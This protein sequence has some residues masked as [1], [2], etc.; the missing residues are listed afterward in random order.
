MK[1]NMMNFEV[2]QQYTELLEK[3][4]AGEFENFEAINEAFDSSIL[5]KFSQQESGDRWRGTFAK[6]FY[7]HAG[8]QLDKITNEDFI[9]LNNPT[10]W[11]TQGYAKNDSAIGFFVDDNPELFKSWDKRLQDRM[12]EQGKKLKLTKVLRNAQGIGLILTIMRGKRGMWHGFQIDNQGSSFRYKKG[13]QERYGVLADQWKTDSKYRYEGVSSPDAKITRKNLEAVATK[14][15]VL[16][17]AALQSKYSSAEIKAA[18]SAAKTG[19]AAFVTAKQVKD[20]NQARYEELLQA[21][22]TP[23]ELWND[24]SGA[25]QKYLTWFTS[26]LGDITPKKAS[27]L[28]NTQVKFGGWSR[29]NLSRPITQM[30]DTISRMASD[31]DYAM[32]DQVHA[33][34]L[35]VEMEKEKDDQK[36]LKLQAEIDYYSR[37]LPRYQQKALDY[38]K[39][40]TG[41]VNDVNAIVK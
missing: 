1:N 22:T 27:E 30:L 17:I 7:K 31:Y 41:Y 18:R 4:N 10:E 5:R 35:A 28:A 2:F 40:I 36:K 23:D 26:K 24:V 34:E 39:T 20:A 19:A 9:I 16:D 38:R 13:A 32:K 29:E 37:A 3:H 14:V 12:K 33:E 6:D 11:W 21:K 8:I 15:Y 25:L